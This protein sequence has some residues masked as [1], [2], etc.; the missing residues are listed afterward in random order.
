MVNSYSLLSALQSFIEKRKVDPNT[1][2]AEDMLALMIDWFRL[3]R[4]DA[5]EGSTA[6][7]VL[8]Y[9]Y[10]GWSE[11]CAT[12]FKVSLLR[13]VRAPQDDGEPVDYFAGITLMFEPA[14][15][16]H[17]KP[18]SVTSNDWATIESFMVTI[19][20]SP[21]YKATAKVVP[22]AVLVESGG[23]R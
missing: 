20:E 18:V 16:A 1:I 22:V 14:A 12:G 15:Y 5:V 13:R 21:A 19:Q 8:M 3:V 7:D 17:L 6:N 23:L 9:R 10:G 4:V 11:G 2:M